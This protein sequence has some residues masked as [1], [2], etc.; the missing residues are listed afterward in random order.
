VQL[1]HKEIKGSRNRT[2]STTIKTT[3]VHNYTV[4]H[5]WV[6]KTR[7]WI[8]ESVHWIIT[9][10]TTNDCN[11]FKIHYNTHVR[12][13]IHMLSLHRSPTENWTA[14]DRQPKN[15]SWCR[16]PS[17]AHD[18]IFITVWQLW[19]CFCGTTSLAW[20][21]VSFLYMLLALASVVFLGSKSLV[22]RDHILLPQVWDFS[23]HCLLRTSG[24]R[25][26]YSTPPPHECELNC[27]C[28]SSYT[29]SARNTQRKSSSIVT[30][31]R[32]HREQVSSFLASVFIGALLP[33]N[34]Q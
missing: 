25:W 32:L 3:P 13:S 22:T 24:S 15:K 1:L 26:R 12:S 20:G 30:W 6:T 5:V 10:L 34:A 17:G 28:Y 31:G 23:F 16:T 9:G 18:Q 27:W 19:S 21:R 33:S 4:S 8:S 14:T 7:V 11:I 2:H 29:A